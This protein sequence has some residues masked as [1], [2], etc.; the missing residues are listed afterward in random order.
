MGLGG[1]SGIGIDLQ[2]LEE[3]RRSYTEKIKKYVRIEF[4]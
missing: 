4:C 3:L 1:K 2:E